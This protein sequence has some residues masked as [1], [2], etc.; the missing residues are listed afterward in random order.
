MW[1]E[2]SFFM[3][4]R[5]GRNPQD[6][7]RPENSPRPLGKSE[8]NRRRRRLSAA[9]RR[10][11]ILGMAGSPLPEYNGKVKDSFRNRKSPLMRGGA[12]RSGKRKPV[13]PGDFEKSADCM[14]LLLML[15][16]LMISLGLGEDAKS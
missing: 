7:L 2:F 3:R 6:F 11:Q 16:R 1:R 5:R 13:F 8:S 9:L 15:E 10:C 12:E 4:D 14:E